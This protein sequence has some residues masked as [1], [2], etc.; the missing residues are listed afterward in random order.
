MEFKRIACSHSI[1]IFKRADTRI[2]IPVFI[3]DMTIAAKLRGLFIGL[4]TSAL[5]SMYF[6]T[7]TLHVCLLW[8]SHLLTVR[9]IFCSLS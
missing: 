3:D 9:T 7:V 6:V 5:F 2:I 1:W 4:V 8:E